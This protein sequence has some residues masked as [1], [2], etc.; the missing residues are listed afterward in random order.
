MSKQE[1]SDLVE[2]G[3]CVKPH[4]I[5]GGFTFVLANK[6]NSV[7]NKGS[8]ILLFPKDKSSSIPSNGKEF[9]VDKI[10]FGNK[11]ITYLTDINDRNDVESMLPFVIKVFR[12][13]FPSTDD[14]EFYIS[15]IIESKVFDHESKDEI[16]T[17]EDFYDNGM[18]IIF[19]IKLNS[20]KV[21]D[22]PFVDTFM[23]EV[24]IEAKRVEIIIPEMI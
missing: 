20:G 14:N 3:F 8:K 18:Q 9:T 1:L 11:V 6:E 13:D 4:G 16:G 5:R 2:L 21:I 12:S 15:D 19:V 7:L 17:V 22:V 10:S 23:P 24:D